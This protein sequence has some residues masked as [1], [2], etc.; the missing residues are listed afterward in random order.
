M[1]YVYPK[2]RDSILFLGIARNALK[3][4]SRCREKSSKTA[5]CQYNKEIPH[6][7][8]FV[9][10]SGTK[11]SG[12]D[13][14]VTALVNNHGFQRI[15]EDANEDELISYVTK[16][17]VKDL[18]MSCTNLSLVEKLDKRPSAVHFSLDAP[19]AIRMKN[20]QR[21]APGKDVNQFFA[22]LDS[23]DFNP[24]S[25]ELRERSHIK[26]KC[27]NKDIANFETR[28]SDAINQQLES[29][30][31][32]NDTLN[33]PLRPSWDT[34]FMKLATLAASRSNCMKRKVGCVIVRER[35]VIA[36]GYN[37][38]PRHLTN[39]F[40][41]GCPR[42]NDG[43]SQNLHTCLCLH[44]EENALLE[45]GRDRIGAH[46]T[47]YCDTCP[48]LTCSVKI[49][50]TGITEVVYSQS[51][52]MDEASFKVLISAGIRV[53]QFSFVKEPKLVMI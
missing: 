23:Y 35:R 50:Q 41:G 24:N 48:C 38:T 47:L 14:A 33:P 20:F 19:V 2:L 16:N 46:A 7:I 49:V 36:T 22:E 9:I 17:Y 10:I 34:Y 1:I 51:Y 15:Y 18:V 31:E 30:R 26:I 39:C 53:R 40:N 12:V 13:I 4:E 29:L 37:G 27:M 42:C 25:I 21:L 43:D 5:T 32:P 52:R 11:Y 8:M 45:A 44:A 28:I 6:D 3:F